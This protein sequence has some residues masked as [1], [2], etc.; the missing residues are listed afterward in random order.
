MVKT[1]CASETCYP[2]VIY[3]VL[4]IIGVALNFLRQQFSISNLIW[5]TS[6]QILFVALWTY[7]LYWLCRKCMSGVAWIVLLAP[8]ILGLIMVFII[9]LAVDL[10]NGQP[11]NLAGR[12]NDVVGL[13]E[14]SVSTIMQQQPEQGAAVAQGSDVLRG[15]LQQAQNLGSLA[16]SNV[17]TI[18]GGAAA[19]GGYNVPTGMSGY[20]AY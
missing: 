9:P 18:A 7:L 17:A 15:D 10:I 14:H 20:G 11:L 2:A 19:S 5:S 6:V 12:L 16:L 8:F 13:A 3:F 4:A 1:S